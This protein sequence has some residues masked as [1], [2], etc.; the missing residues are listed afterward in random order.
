MHGVSNNFSPKRNNRIVSAMQM[1]FISCTVGRENVIFFQIN[2]NLSAE[3]V[4]SSMKCSDLK[5][6]FSY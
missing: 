6:F 2:V 4:L 5:L 1:Q 3:N